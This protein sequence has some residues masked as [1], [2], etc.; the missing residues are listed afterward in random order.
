MYG[1]GRYLKLLGASLDCGEDG[2]L[3]WCGS[4]DEI[5]SGKRLFLCYEGFQRLLRTLASVFTGLGDQV[6]PR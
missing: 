2:G 3:Y 4:E 6:L 5:V 1:E